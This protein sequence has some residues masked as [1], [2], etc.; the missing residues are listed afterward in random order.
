MYRFPLFVSLSLCDHNPPT[1]QTDRQTDG[2]TSRSHKKQRDM[3]DPRSRS[4]TVQ[5]LQPVL[6]FL[7]A[8]WWRSGVVTPCAPNLHQQAEL[9]DLTTSFPPLAETYTRDMFQKSSERTVV[10][11]GG[12][13]CSV[14]T[15]CLAPRSSLYKSYVYNAK[16]TK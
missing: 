3:R 7:P 13:G 4:A 12:G 15:N 16:T 1:L 14:W 6:T 2:R 8:R 9:V 5:F 11:L 10:D